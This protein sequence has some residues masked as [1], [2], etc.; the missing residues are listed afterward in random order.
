MTGM[1]RVPRSRGAMSG[2]LLV[3]LGLWGGLVPL[4]GPYVHFAYTP[5][6][7]WVITS[8]RIWLEI[9]PGAVVL[10]GGLMAALTRFRPA[11][12]TGAVLAVLGGAWFVVGTILTPLRTAAIS[13]GVPVG[14]VAIRT[15]EQLS[16]FPGLGAVI[17]F[18]AA[19]ALVVSAGITNPRGFWIHW[20]DAF[21]A[22]VGTFL[23][24]TAAVEHYR[25]SRNL[26]DPSFAYVEALA[27]L[28]LFALY[29]TTRTIRGFHSRPKLP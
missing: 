5:D 13:A 2:A 3:L 11:A 23:F 27:F 9:V 8:G 19:I 7:P 24:G 1:L 20:V 16:F 22:A 6:R 28:S 29:F 25:A 10:V 14:G 21:F 15:A 4:I 26:F 18:I 12:V 17:I